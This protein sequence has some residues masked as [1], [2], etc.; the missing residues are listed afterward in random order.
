M[1]GRWYGELVYDFNLWNAEVESE[2]FSLFQKNINPDTMEKL[3]QRNATGG[4]RFFDFQC[5]APKSVSVMSMFDERLVRAHSKA[6][7]TAM[8]EMEKLAAVRLRKG[9]QVR[10]NNYEI[11]GKIIY[12]SFRHDASRALDPQLHTHNVVCNVTKTADGEFKALESLEMVRAIRYAGKV[13]HNELAKICHDLGY[14]TV[15]HLDDKGSIVWFDIEGVSGEVMEVFSKRRGQIEAQEKKFIE[16]HG[17]KPTLAENNFISMT[18]RDQ[19]LKEISGQEVREY[20]FEQLTHAQKHTLK[21]LAH[22]AEIN[23]MKEGTAGREATVEMIQAALPVVYERDS[24][25][26]LDKV[27]AETLN[28][29]LG[30]IDLKTLKVAVN[31]VEELKNLGG[32]EV[33]PY[34]STEKIIQQELYAI[35]SVETQ[36]DLF[37][38]IASNFVAFPGQETRQKQAELIHGMLSSRD[39]FNLFRGVAGAGKTSTLQELCKGLRSGG[40]ESIHLIAPTNSAT[41]VLKQEGFEQSQTVASFLLSREKPPAGS[42]VIIDE[43][44]LNSLREGVEIVK[45]ARANNYRVLFVGDARQH[46]AVENG[47]FFR[48]LEEHSEIE[49]FSL[50]DIHRQQNEEYRRG[51]SDCALGRFDA[52]FERFDANGFIHEGKNKYLDRAADSYMEYTENGQFIDRAILVAPTHDEGDELTDAV[53]SKLKDSGSIKGDGRTQEIFRSW[54][55]PKARL[56]DAGNYQPGMA[57]AFIRNMKDIAK[58]GET[59]KIVGIDDDNLLLDNGKAIYAKRCAEF[60]EVGERSEIELCEGDLIQFNVNLRDQRIYNGNIAMITADPDKVM[61]LYSDG[62]PRELVDMPTGYNTFKYGWVTTSYKSQGRTAENVVVAAQSLDRKAFYVAL[63]RGRQHMALHCPE[64][65]FLKA[66]LSLNSDRNSVHDLVKAGEIRPNVILHLSEEAREAKAKTLPDTTYKSVKGRAARIMEYVK[67]LPRRI[68]ENAKDAVARRTRFNKYGYGI[69]TEKTYFEQGIR[70]AVE[71]KPEVKVSKKP[72]SRDADNPF[73]DKIKAF[74]EGQSNVSS[75][76]KPHVDKYPAIPMP[77]PSDTERPKSPAKTA[78]IDADNP[79][80]EKIKAFTE[81]QSVSS[82]PKPHIDKYPAISIPIPADTKQPTPSAKTVPI[83]TDNPFQEKIKAVGEKQQNTV[84]QPKPYIDK[85]PAISISV[86]SDTEQPKSPAKA[87]PIDENNPFREKVKTFTEEQRNISS[88]PKSHEDKY[89][90]VPISTPADM[91]RPKS[92]AKAASIDADNPF[93]EKIMAYVEKQRN[94]MDQPELSRDNDPPIEGPASEANENIPAAKKE[95]SEHETDLTPHRTVDAKNTMTEQS[96]TEDITN[97]K[98]STKPIDE[99][100]IEDIPVLPK[101]KT[102][103]GMDL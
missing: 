52:A 29:N 78:S 77:V 45:V 9:D 85:Y 24:V 87:V 41:D 34:Y 100:E 25:L 60:I 1:V 88:Q 97:E 63:S 70:F 65:E 18:T 6:V 35:E 36:K 98:Q 50:T 12:A 102:P 93:L 49:R 58:A 20:Q 38:P 62:Q 79:F 86:P 47:D 22:E 30:R 21:L 73:L 4:P 37:E 84:S 46:N 67:E 101:K 11:T 53:R 80:R 8:R 74:A 68:Y 23:F 95:K 76:P 39:R 57:V 33:N 19:K 28:Q 54:N 81:G 2:T 92:P 42:Y 48:L 83:D 51:I 15:N 59:A 69:V 44:G 64:K 103:R 31:D 10:T 13:Y 56:R 72:L 96:K 3:T 14:K 17:R 40:I 91:E 7:L 66:R 32:L 55:W 43:S 82:Q 61:M 26:K 75:Q 94:T 89:P 16:E 90:T 5:A 99:P 27:L 71:A